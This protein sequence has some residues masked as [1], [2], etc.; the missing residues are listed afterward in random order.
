MWTEIKECS[1]KEFGFST[2]ANEDVHRYYGITV[3]TDLHPEN[4]FTKV[5][6][7][8]YK[9][10]YDFKHTLVAFLKER[11]NGIMK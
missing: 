7:N 11:Y 4:L 6:S 2:R 1:R 8:C 10:D 5:T 3:F 9:K